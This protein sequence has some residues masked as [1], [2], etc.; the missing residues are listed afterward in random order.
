MSTTFSHKTHK[1]QKPDMTLQSEQDFQWKII[2]IFI[3]LSHKAIIWLQKTFNIAVVV[4][5]VLFGELSERSHLKKFTFC[6]DRNKW[7]EDKQNIS[8]ELFL[9]A[10]GVLANVQRLEEWSLDT[11]VHLLTWA[12]FPKTQKS[13]QISSTPAFVL[14]HHSFSLSTL[15]FIINTLTQWLP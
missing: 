1:D 14:T 15:L 12:L 2:K 10:V 4:L 7:H 9:W 5:F 3:F 6:I 8:G 11:S 13:C